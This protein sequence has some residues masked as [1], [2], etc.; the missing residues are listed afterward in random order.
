M[1][2]KV[3]SA[4]TAIPMAKVTKTKAASV[5]LPTAKTPL[6]RGGVARL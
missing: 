2:N 1:T 6:P 5:K 3:T 4:S